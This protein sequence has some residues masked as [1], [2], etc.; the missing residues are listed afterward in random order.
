MCCFKLSIT[1][2]EVVLGKYD[3][4]F[5][6]EPE[7]GTWRFITGGTAYGLAILEPPDRGVSNLVSTYGGVVAGNLDEFN[8]VRFDGNPSFGCLPGFA[9]QDLPGSGSEL[10][11]RRALDG[12]PSYVPPRGSDSGG[13]VDFGD[14]FDNWAPRCNEFS[15]AEQA[16]T[17]IVGPGCGAPP[18]LNGPGDVA[19]GP[20][21]NPANP[22]KALRSGE[23]QAKITCIE[24]ADEETPGYALQASVA[25]VISIVHV[26]PDDVKHQKK[27]L[28]GYI[29]KESP[30][31]GDN[32]A[33]KA[34]PRKFPPP[35]SG[36]SRCSTSS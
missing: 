26:S 14:P 3:Q 10:P 30:L 35:G 29:G 36:T 18:L 9:G 7:S 22:T 19:G 15:D 17:K 8:T 20:I 13:L 2:Y 25:F 28:R 23:H 1:E 12:A 31:L 16:V 34:L 4:T 5:G 27:V 33:G 11:F 24:E 32:A 6:G 21:C